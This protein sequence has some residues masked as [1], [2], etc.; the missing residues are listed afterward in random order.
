M[1]Y[2]GTNFANVY[3]HTI[4]GN[5]NIECGI[6]YN[7]RITAL[8]AAGESAPT[9]GQIRVGS[10]P[11]APSGLIMTAITPSVD[12]TLKWQPPSSTGCLPI[13]GYIVNKNGVDLVTVI[14]PSQNSYIDDISIGGTIGTTIDY[15]IKAINVAGP[16]P[17]TETLTITVGEIPNAPTNL[18]IQDQPSS[19]T[20]N[21]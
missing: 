3:T 16:S 8:N 18:R 21:L 19:T 7:L 5:E 6:T 20:V 17:Y 4:S 11:T 2:D 10:I 14:S 1:A 13:T 9:E 15:K 12:L